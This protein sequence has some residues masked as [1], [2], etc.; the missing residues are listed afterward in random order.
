MTDWPIEAVSSK[1]L[2]LAI[3]E[4]E[5]YNTKPVSIGIVHAQAPKRIVRPA[6]NHRGRAVPFS[7]P[8]DFEA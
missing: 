3:V 5:T 1:L 7:S 6:S 4:K 2:E 8:T